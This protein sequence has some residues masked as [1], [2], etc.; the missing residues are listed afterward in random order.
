MVYHS[1]SRT[2][3]HYLYSTHTQTL[4]II[5]I[6]SLKHSNAPP[7]GCILRVIKSPNIYCV[8]DIDYLEARLRNGLE[9][10]MNIRCIQNSFLLC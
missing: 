8:D 7:E 10:A 3:K 1:A 5:I 2:T 9:T 4:G 6:V